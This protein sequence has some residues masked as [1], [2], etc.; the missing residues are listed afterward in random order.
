MLSEIVRDLDGAGMCGMRG[1]RPSGGI[2][3]LGHRGRSYAG[4][5]DLVGGGHPLRLLASWLC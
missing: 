5:Q 3:S 2:V 1:L 4:R